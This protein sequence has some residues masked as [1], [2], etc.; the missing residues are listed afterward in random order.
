[1]M[2]M[3]VLMMDVQFTLMIMKETTDVD[4]D[5]HNACTTDTCLDSQEGVNTNKLIGTFMILVL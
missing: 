5:D 2:T 3:L 4:C 1:M